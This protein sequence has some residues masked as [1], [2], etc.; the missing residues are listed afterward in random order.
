MDYDEVMS[1]LKSMR[2]RFD[3]G[4][5]S[6]DRSYL[7]SL[8]YEL[9]GKVI[10]NRGCSDCYRD[11]F[12]LIVNHLKKTKAMP[13]KCN[14]RLKPGVVIQFFGKSAVYTNPN[15]TDEVA[16]KYLGLN[17]DN[18]RMFSDLPS[19]WETRVAARVTG[20]S[21]DSDSNTNSSNEVI[22]ALT[23]KLTA[24]EKQLADEREKNRSLV[25]E[26]DKIK[27]DLDLQLNAPS[28]EVDTQ[29]I[30]NLNLELENLR[31]ENDTLKNENES[32]K[33][34]ISTLKNENRALKSAN[35]RLKNGEAKESD[36]AE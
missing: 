24:T 10:T 34:D 35:T 30:D 33:S 27:S 21:A 9:F 13:Q 8:H 18:K 17:S 31:A 29:E 15:L 6:L 3:D 2:S 4:F 32:L 14:Y 5:S 22:S 28:V 23:D 20:T 19:D 7:D 25:E 26:I 16:E 36:S 12:I 11:A 1:N